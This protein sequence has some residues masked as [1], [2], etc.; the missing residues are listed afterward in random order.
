MSLALGIGFKTRTHIVSTIR[1]IEQF[2]RGWRFCMAE[3]VP[4]EMLSFGNLNLIAN[5]TCIW[6]KADNHGL[7]RPDNPGSDGWRTVDLPHDF[8]IEGEFSSKAPLNN[9]SLSGGRAFYVKKFALPA[10]D[11]GKRLRLEFDGVYR[12]A[13]VHVNGHFIARHMSGYT[14]FGCDITEVCRFGMMNAVSVHVDATENELWSYEGGG[15]YRGV[16]LV[17]TALLHVPQWGA[18]IVTGGENDPGRA[19]IRV[20]VR[21]A[22]YNTTACAAAVHVIAPDGSIAASSSA[23]VFSVEPFTDGEVLASAKVEEPLLW[24]VD[25]PHLYRAVIEL[26]ADGAVVDRYEQMFGF[27]YFRFDPDTGFWLNGQNMKLRGVCCHQDHAGVGVA[28]PPAL[29]EWRVRQLKEIGTNAIRTSHNPPD[30]ALLDACDRLGMMVMDEIRMPGI[31]AEHLGNVESLIRRD[32]NHPSVILWSL[33]NEEMGIQNNETGVR[34]FR[35]LQYLSH[36]LAPTRPTT[37][38]MNCDW[39]NVSKFHDEHDFRFDVFGANYRSGQKSEHYDE[40]HARYPDWPILGSETWGGTCTRGLYEPDV[41]A[42]PVRIGERWEKN[43]DS[44]HGAEHHGYCSAYQNWRTPWGYSIEECWRDCVSRPF[45]AGTFIWTGFDYRGETSPYDWPAVI[46]RYGILDLCGFWKEVAHYLR[47]W[48]RPEI[49]HLFLMPHWNWEGR[50]GKPVN[51]W[52]YGNTKAVELFL[53]GRSLGKKEMPLNDKITW[54]VPW[55]PGK[56]EAKGYDTSGKLIASTARVTAGT[57]AALRLSSDRNSVRADGDDVIVIVAA[58]VDG[59]GEVCPRADN[60]V[61]FIVEGPAAI[62]GV[63]NGNPMSHEPDKYTN[64]RKAFHGLCQ[65]ILK[66]TGDAGTVSVRAQCGTLTAGDYSF[67]AEK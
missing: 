21:N 9:G 52:C 11:R 57:P 44:W 37:Y 26:S 28:V 54:Q 45:M 66:S 56:L 33:G 55:A 38:G 5:E 18:H 50:E 4:A 62:L 59:C 60:E 1:T 23:P 2:D 47:S 15:I 53:N 16:R 49:P 64:R 58:V 3:K 65:V 51:V 39:I 25:M 48:W 24:G 22:S 20:T 30:P 17:K 14:S 43:A 46:T 63:A 67:M 32:R 61:V 31:E 40:F 19:D 34:I 12:E 7:S 6:Q 42:T 29:Q 36:Q 10:E 27:R 35:R 41:S 8:V 13:A